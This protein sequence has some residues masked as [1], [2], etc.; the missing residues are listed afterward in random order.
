SLTRIKAMAFNCCK[1][2]ENIDLPCELSYIDLAAFF[3]CT[4]LKNIEFPYRLRLIDHRAFYACS[5]LKYITALGCI[6]SIEEGAF[7]ECSSLNQKYLSGFIEELQMRKR[8]I[9]CQYYYTELPSKVNKQE[10]K[11]RKKRKIKMKMT[12]R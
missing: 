12:K 6:I 8:G 9:D 11:V 7:D 5:S 4:A 2:L 3:Y 1:S 10:L